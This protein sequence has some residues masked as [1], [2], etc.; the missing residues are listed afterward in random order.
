MRWLHCADFHIGQDRTVQARLLDKIVEHITGQVLEGFVPD[1]VFITR[2]LA[3]KG[4]NVEF[5][6][7]RK[8]FADPLLRSQRGG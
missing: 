1:L 2:E 8:D 4:V 7:F 5:N 3:N 6:N